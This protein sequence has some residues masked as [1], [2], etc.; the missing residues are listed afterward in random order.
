MAVGITMTGILITSKQLRELRYF[1]KNFSL[2]VEFCL[3]CF[4]RVGP[5]STTLV[6]TQGGSSGSPVVDINGRVVGINAGSKHKSSSAYFLPLDRVQRALR[7][8]AAKA[9]KTPQEDWQDTKVQRGTLQAVFVFKG[10]DEARRLG[11]SRPTE[12][13]IRNETNEENTGLL[14][15]ETVVPGGPAEGKILEGDALIRIEGEVV[16]DFVTLES[17]IDYRVGANVTL[18]LE[19]GG[20]HVREVVPVQDLDEISPSSFLQM[21][22]GIIHA[23]SHQQARG[24]NT[25]YGQVSIFVLRFCSLISGSGFSQFW[26]KCAGLRCRFGTCTFGSST[27][28]RYLQLESQKSGQHD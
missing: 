21:G 25:H 27:A 19:R 15:A 18:D 26:K 24:Y 11:L 16:T 3:G 13:S 6:V 5:D 14:Q 23:L 28:R 4:E 20:E 10:Y 1:F 7:E 8:L 22:G 17:H 12:A 2:V 9:P